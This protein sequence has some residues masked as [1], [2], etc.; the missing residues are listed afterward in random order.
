MRRMP[1][2][3]ADAGT[4][5]REWKQF[6]TKEY[7][8]TR[9]NSPKPGRRERYSL[10]SLPSTKKSLKFQGRMKEWSENVWPQSINARVSSVTD[11]A[12]PEWVILPPPFRCKG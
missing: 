9:N 3:S 5:S 10:R 6:R 7:S 8:G 4:D 12:P 2:T 1:E 11:R